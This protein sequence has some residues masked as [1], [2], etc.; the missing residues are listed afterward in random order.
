MKMLLASVMFKCNHSLNTE[1]C[2]CIPGLGSCFVFCFCF[3]IFLRCC[4]N[5]IHTS[6]VGRNYVTCAPGL[7]FNMHWCDLKAAWAWVGNTVNQHKRAHL[8][9]AHS[10]RTSSPVSLMGYMPSDYTASL[11][12]SNHVEREEPNPVLKSKNAISVNQSH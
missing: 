4:C 1:L 3:F 2:G 7:D 12:T 8:P 5:H 11:S 6:T 9:L 10:R